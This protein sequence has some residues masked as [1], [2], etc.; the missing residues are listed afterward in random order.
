[1]LLNSLRQS[2]ERNALFP[3]LLLARGFEDLGVSDKKVLGCG[4]NSLFQ[5]GYTSA[6][7][8]LEDEAKPHSEELKPGGLSSSEYS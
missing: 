1:M 3:G 2:I 7:V 5:R 8:Q 6:L 4:G